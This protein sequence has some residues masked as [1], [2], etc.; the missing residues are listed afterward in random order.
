MKHCPSLMRILLAL[1]LFAIA[2][3]F[4]YHL[5]RYHRSPAD[6]A[7]AAAE[8]TRRDVKVIFH[9]SNPENLP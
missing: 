5:G 2:G 7:A 9:T 1:A 4:G 6:M 8:R 3:F